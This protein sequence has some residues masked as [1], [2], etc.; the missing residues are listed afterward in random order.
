MTTREI[1]VPA[2]T[3]SR[4]GQVIS[5]RPATLARLGGDIAVKKRVPAVDQDHGYDVHEVPESLLR[6]PQQ[7]S[8]A[9][10]NGVSSNA[11]PHNSHVSIQANPNAGLTEFY[12]YL[13][14]KR[15]CQLIEQA[16]V[17]TSELPEPTQLLGLNYPEL[18]T[19]V[20]QVP[21]GLVNVSGTVAKA[22][23]IADLAIAYPNARIMILSSRVAELKFVCQSLQRD[24]PP[25]MSRK[26]LLAL[27]WNR[28][29]QAVVDDA[30]FPRIIC[31]TP[32]A[33]ADLDSEKA[34]IVVLLDAFDCLHERMAWPLIQTDAR[35]RLFGLWTASRKP[36]K[37]E[38]AR[39]RTVFGFQQIDLMDRGR[40]RRE[41]HYAYLRQGGPAPTGSTYVPCAAGDRRSPE[42]VD[43][44]R[45]YIHNHQRNEQIC[46]LARKLR[47][48]VPLTGERY[49]DVIQWLE[50]RSTQNLCVTIVVDRLEHAIQLGNHLPKWPI[51]ADPRIPLNDLPQSVR[52]RINSNIT[53]WVPCR[54]VAPYVGCR[55]SGYCSDIVIWASGGVAAEI[56][57]HWMYSINSPSQPL[58]IVD[59]LDDFTPATRKLS[60]SR[61][62]D[63]KKRDVYRVGTPAVMGR[64]QQL[65]QIVRGGR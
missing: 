48:G 44:Q 55:V 26:N 57:R 36:T 59:F 29:P 64:I 1:A 33:A 37:Y 3:Y 30:D 28:S 15:N 2:L 31:C 52:S 40:V 27:V 62:Q 13:A 4:N 42:S 34:D 6:G 60:I 43:P 39:L 17:P 12:R 18:A 35:F 41:V 38:L 7:L 19:F 49:R 54:I 58:L 61:M 45:A 9:P 10:G 8:S 14:G 20:R 50:G 22:V 11:S 63:L 16:D 24:L 25:S 46:R 5:L 21:R 23:L 56:P 32:T 47:T 65:E 51:V 53:E